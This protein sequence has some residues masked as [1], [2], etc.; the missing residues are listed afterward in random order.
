MDSTTPLSTAIT[1]SL[2]VT[3]P[4]GATGQVGFSNEGYSGVPV[5]N[6]TYANYFWIKGAYSGSI[7]LELVGNSS[8]IVYASQNITV[9]SVASEFTYYETTYKSTQSPDGNNVWRLT[10]NG[11][12]V[13]GSS[14]WFDLVQLFP[15][16]Y[17][18]R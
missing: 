15:V 17:H 6:D 8:G 4:S 11:A 5:N 13:A 16:T 9:D 18:Q 3:V 10:F 7:L 12:T 14:L 1:S 2:K